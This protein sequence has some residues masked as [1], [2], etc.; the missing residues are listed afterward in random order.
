MTNQPRQRRHAR[1]SAFTLAELMVSVAILLVAMLAVGY[2]F[3]GVSKTSSL[4]MANIELNDALA[5]IQQTMQA[6]LQTLAP[7][8]FLIHS[9]EPEN[10][11]ARDFT[12]EPLLTQNRSDAFTCVSSG[13]P[14]LFQSYWNPAVYS[15]DAILFYGHGMELYNKTLRDSPNLFDRVYCRRAVLLV[16]NLFPAKDPSWG[17]GMG[18]TDPNYLPPMSYGTTLWDSANA[19]NFLNTNIQWSRVDVIQQHTATDLAIR[20]RDLVKNGEPY[21]ALIARNLAPAEPPTDPN[22]VSERGLHCFNLLHHVGDV[23]VEW[24]DGSMANPLAAANHPDRLRLQWFGRGRDVDGNGLIRTAIQLEGSTDVVSYTAWIAQQPGKVRPFAENALAP[25]TDGTPPEKGASSPLGVYMAAWTEQSWAYRPKAI[26]MTV[27]LYD[28]NK[29]FRD[30]N[31][32]LG[33]EFS[34]VLRVP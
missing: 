4:T 13:P 28:V 16:P 30:D 6:D 10:R 7:V 34:F 17:H 15:P 25:T 18:R 21:R 12:G 27:R 3:S 23:I 32:R 19:F 24:T 2:I 22:Y 26:R 33:K 20:M 29:R 11:S 8:V 1:R 31:D 14:R 5:V 9:P